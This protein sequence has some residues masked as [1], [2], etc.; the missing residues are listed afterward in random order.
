MLSPLTASADNGVQ[1]SAT[2]QGMFE[3]SGWYVG[4]DLGGA[5]NPGAT[6]WNCNNCQNGV[7]KINTLLNEKGNSGTVT[8]GVYGGYQ[9][10]WEAP[11]VTGFELDFNGLGDIRKNN[12][13]SA[14]VGVGAAIPAGTYTLATGRDTNFFGTVRGHFG[15]IPAPDME[16]Y[17]SGGL[18]YAGNSG[19]GTGSVTYTAPGGATTTWTS[20]GSDNKTKIGSAFGAGFSWAIM[21]NLALRVEGMYIDLKSQD[22]SFTVVGQT[23]SLDETAKFHFTVARAGLTYKF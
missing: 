8:G 22:R 21:D 1:A 7:N 15:Y 2:T 4:I 3:R 9:Y 20:N 13:E 18:A 12:S 23:Y 11:V 14:T 17:I 19:G 5:F 16:I 10:R 6:S